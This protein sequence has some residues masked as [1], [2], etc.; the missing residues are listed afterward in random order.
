MSDFSDKFPKEP[1]E[2]DRD[3]IERELKRS[4]KGKGRGKP[5]DDVASETQPEKKTAPTST[6]RRMFANGDLDRET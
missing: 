3:T 4:E 6:G 1:S 2:G 5:K